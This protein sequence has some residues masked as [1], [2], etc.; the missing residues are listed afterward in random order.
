[1]KHTVSPQE[2]QKLYPIIRWLLDVKDANHGMPT[3]NDVDMTVEKI[4]EWYEA[5]NTF[6]DWISEDGWYKY[7]PTCQR[8][9]TARP[10]AFPKLM[11]R[12]LRLL[13]H[14]GKP[15]TVKELEKESGISRQFDESSHFPLLRHWGLVQRVEGSKYYATPKAK[16]VLLMED[17]VESYVWVFNDEKLETPPPNESH[18]AMAYISELRHKEYDDAEIFNASVSAFTIPTL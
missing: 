4:C 7:C 6:S 10:L 2:K 8:R 14:F 1:M 12:Y 16:R 5:Q 13:V 3:M 18:G 17:K 9:Y 15:M 11:M